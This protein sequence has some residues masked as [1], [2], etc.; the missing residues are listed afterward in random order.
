M[1]ACVP[2]YCDILIATGSGK[3]TLAEGHVEL[4]RAGMAWR[5]WDFRAVVLVGC[6]QCGARKGHRCRCPRGACNSTHYRR[7]D[8]AT[9]LLRGKP[10]PWKTG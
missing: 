1:T 8:N 10:L 7:R 2:P 9:A 3:L 6:P 4:V 5:W